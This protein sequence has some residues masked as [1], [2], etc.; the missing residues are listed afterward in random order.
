[1]AWKSSDEFWNTTSRTS[2]N[3]DDDFEIISSR[4]YISD[5]KSS[6]N[7]GSI[8]NYDFESASAQS[9]LPIESLLSRRNLEAVLNDVRI[10]YQTPTPSVQET[11]IKMF[12]G[13]P[14]S[15]SVYRSLSQKLDLLDEAIASEDGNIILAVLLFLKKTLEATELYNH[16]TKRKVAY[17]HYSNYLME[18]LLEQEL[19]NLVIC[20]GNTC[21][22]VYVYGTG[23]EKD[24][25]K[26]KVQIK[27]LKFFLDYSKMMSSEQRAMFTEYK[28]F[29]GWQI[30]NKLSC[31]T[32]TE[33]LAF[34][35]KSQWETKSD[36]SN[37]AKQ[38][39]DFR[40][41]R[42][43]ND[44]QYEWIVI[45]ALCTFEMWER[46]KHLFIKP[47]STVGVKRMGRQSFKLIISWQ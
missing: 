46:L 13:M 27:L 30:E 17:R 38:I 42:H 29:I 11:V 45:N 31:H 8:V 12:L 26:D 25:S 41:Q 1:M 43:L 20:S 36:G 7:L 24:M 10:T 2:F 47:V 14:Y 22:L 44:F 6:D 5:S 28:N 16:I 23:L 39:I 32:L 35:C 19:A 37:C 3:F 40:A 4:S 34:L 15:L 33:E 21:D 9:L 18:E